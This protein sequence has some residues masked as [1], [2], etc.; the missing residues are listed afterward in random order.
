[1]NFKKVTRN[2]IDFFHTIVGKQFVFIDEESLE[3]YSKDETEDLS[4]LPEVVI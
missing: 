4:Y 3:K 2:D 1:M